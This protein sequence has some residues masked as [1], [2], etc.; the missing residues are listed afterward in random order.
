MMLNQ[1]ILKHAAWAI[2]GISGGENDLLLTAERGVVENHAYLQ[3]KN[4][5]N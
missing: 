2:S 4:H 3:R 5:K 1:F